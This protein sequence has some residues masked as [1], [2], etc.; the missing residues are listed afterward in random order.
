M[1][2]GINLLPCYYRTLYSK[3]S[4]YGGKDELVRISKGCMYSTV[5]TC[6]TTRHGVYSSH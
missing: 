6:I 3:V 2:R 4:L 5:H 1:I